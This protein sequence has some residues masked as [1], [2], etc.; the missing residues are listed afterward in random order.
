MTEP[1]SQLIAVH[2]ATNRFEADLL[3]DALTQ[4][5][6]PVVL[7][8]FEETPYSGLFVPQR[9]WGKILVPKD[10][11]SQARQIV[12]SVLR[13][14]ESKPPYVDPAGVDPLLWEQ[15]QEADP[16][17]VCRNAQVRYDA[18]AFAYLVT[19]LNS[20]YRCLPH[21]RS[22]EAVHSI[23]GREPSFEF[24][25]V[26]LHYLLEA[27][28]I[29]IAGEWIS[30]KDIPGGTLFFQGPHQFPTEPLLKSF[31]NHPDLFSEAAKKLGGTQV[32]AGDMAFR[33]WAL[34]CVPLLF[35]LWVGD[36]E[37]EPALH[38]RFD[39]TINRHLRGLDVILALVNVVCRHL[40]A[41]VG[42]LG[43]VSSEQ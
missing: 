39:S 41:A 16:A 8:P 25:L 23:P 14:C 13:S 12:Q 15:L 24:Y 34:P 5:G 30:E 35:I 22:I 6:V 10:Q 19:F 21:Q 2:T 18:E 40:R 4:E 38:I 26:M 3:M 42:E 17:T 1:S 32:D 7:R 9:G 29:G 31:G 36:E 20:D 27:Q 11:A 37:F 28:P 43:T 33:L